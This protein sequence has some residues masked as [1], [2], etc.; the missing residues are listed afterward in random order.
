MSYSGVQ[1]AIEEDL[2]DVV[3]VFAS[4]LPLSYLSQS[5]LPDIPTVFRY[6]A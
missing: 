5:L 2:S 3:L 1:E 6:K 4:S